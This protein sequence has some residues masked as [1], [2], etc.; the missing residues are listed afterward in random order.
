MVRMHT[1]HAVYAN[2]YETEKKKSRERVYTYQTFFPKTPWLRKSKGC[3]G[4]S[5]Y[6]LRR[7]DWGNAFYTFREAWMYPLCKV[8]PF[9]F[10]AKYH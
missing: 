7:N 5:I 10:S 8:R 4:K 1:P 6:Y 2:P 9:T 3:L